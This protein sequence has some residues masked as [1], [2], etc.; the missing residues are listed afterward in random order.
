MYTLNGTE[1]HAV[2]YSLGGYNSAAWLDGK[3]DT[4]CYITETS[5]TLDSN[6]CCNPACNQ[7]GICVVEVHGVGT[8]PA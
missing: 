2:C 5:R 1:V 8:S 7:G 6:N 4:G 3:P